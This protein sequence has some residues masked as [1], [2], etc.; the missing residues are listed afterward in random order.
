MRRREREEGGKE[1]FNMT[2]S[3]AFRSGA[4]QAELVRP[5]SACMDAFRL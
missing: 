3:E 4:L 2:H 1:V 5:S